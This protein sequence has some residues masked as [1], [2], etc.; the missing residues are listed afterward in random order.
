MNP[1]IKRLALLLFALSM[2][3][4]PLGWT[5]L[6]F[7]IPPMTVGIILGVVCSFSIGV[8]FTVP[9]AFP[10]QIAAV[11]AKETGKDRA[12]MYFAVQGLVN[13]FMGSLAGA[14]LAL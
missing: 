8:F 9:Y 5:E 14:A 12:G 6:N 3:L 13:Q 4:Y 11:E 10:A 1:R 2:L 7:P